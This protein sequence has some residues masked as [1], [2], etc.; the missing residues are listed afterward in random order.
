LLII[1]TDSSA[2]INP[3]LLIISTDSSAI[4]NPFLLIISTDSS[5]IINPFLH[6]S[7]FE[8]RFEFMNS[9]TL[10]VKKS[11]KDSFIE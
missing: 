4:I 2:I 10:T 6:V 3:F 9:F 1:F 11:L 7:D 5:A 8:G